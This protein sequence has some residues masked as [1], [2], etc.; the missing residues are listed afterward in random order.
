MSDRSKP[1]GG[2]KS[3]K[4][5]GRPSS[6]DTPSPSKANGGNGAARHALP[7]TPGAG[8]SNGSSN[9]S[10][11]LEKQLLEWAGA[12]A[13]N[14]PEIREELVAHYREIIAEGRYHPDPEEIAERMIRKG[15]LRDI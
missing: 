12:S 7:A 1:R 11:G 10:N 8:P 14:A 2:P 3:R 4:G 9:G 5:A 15:L 13:R 6:P